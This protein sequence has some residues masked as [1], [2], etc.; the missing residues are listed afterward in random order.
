MAI[1]A[2]VA[3][4]LSQRLDYAVGL[5]AQLPLA[6]AVRESGDAGTPLVLSAP[7]DPGA[8]ALI[9]LAERLTAPA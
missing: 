8:A 5:V 4:A 6:G 2:R 1:S 9:A 3:A 7:D